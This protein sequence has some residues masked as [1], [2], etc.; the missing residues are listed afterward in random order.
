MLWLLGC[1]SRV[2]CSCAG[3]DRLSEGQG[4][5]R[6]SDVP[7]DRNKKLG[8]TISSRLCDWKSVG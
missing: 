8:R 1:L 7:M 2:W 6:T 4:K 5:G 3:P